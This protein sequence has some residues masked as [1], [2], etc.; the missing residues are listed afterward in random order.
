MV[1]IQEKADERGKVHRV[2]D[3]F[4]GGFNIDRPEQADQIAKAL[5]KEY[6]TANE[7]WKTT[8]VGYTD[9]AV[10]I[11]DK[12]GMVGEVRLS[13][14]ACPAP[15]TNK[16]VMT[17]TRMR[18][19]S[20][21]PCGG[22]SSNS[23]RD[24][25]R[26]DELNR[27]QSDLYGGVLKSSAATGSARSSFKRRPWPAAAAREGFVEFSLGHQARH[28]TQLKGVDLAPTL[29]L[30][31]Q[32]EAVVG[33]GVPDCREAFEGS[34]ISSWRSP[35]DKRR[36]GPR[37]GPRLT[38]AASCRKAKASPARPRRTIRPGT[39]SSL[40]TSSGLIS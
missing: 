21:R 29:L 20:R 7:N 28:L 30:A 35:S 13:R 32:H 15:R 1:R 34:S 19:S 31:P 17:C 16:A 10:S 12:N 2:S 11:R 37:R 3:L 4:R 38:E 14:R 25:A 26:I 40:S 6:G 9:K 8:D 24:R 18:R 5:A 23:N 33:A 36:S 27:Q 22:R 39:Y